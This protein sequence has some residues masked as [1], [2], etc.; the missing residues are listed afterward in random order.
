MLLYR[1]YS[2]QRGSNGTGQ[3]CGAKGSDFRVRGAV[4]GSKR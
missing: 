1:P 3:G 2:N 4:K